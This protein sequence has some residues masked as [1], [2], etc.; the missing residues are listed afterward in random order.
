MRIEE[1]IKQKKFASPQQRAKVNI[2]YTA[3]W[4]NQHDSQALKQYGI[5]IQQ[6]NILR[7]LRGRKGKPATVKLLTERML[8]KMSNASRLV[9]KLVAKNLV[10]RCQSEIDRRS[11]EV[12]ITKSGIDVLNDAS[13][14]LDFTNREC[15]DHL[16]NEEA[17]QLSKLLDKIRS[18]E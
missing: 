6:F 18:P 13:K 10:K 12:T 9:D 5:S 4:V 3:A 8:D 14:S 1:A 11:V 17:C 7:I 15:F 2:I 16:S